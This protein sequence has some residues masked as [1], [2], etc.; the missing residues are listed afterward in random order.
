MKEQMSI[1]RVRMKIY[2]LHL[3]CG[4]N[5]D[6]VFLILCFINFIN[7]LFFAIMEILS[8]SYRSYIHKGQEGTTVKAYF[9]LVMINENVFQTQ[10]NNDD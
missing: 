1:K 6:G 4:N 9:M 2:F 5:S 10:N 8:R 3:A 7:V